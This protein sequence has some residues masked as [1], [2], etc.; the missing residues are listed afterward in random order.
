MKDWT[1]FT[2]MGVVQFLMASSLVGSILMEPG[3]MRRPRYSTLVVLKVHLES[4]RARCSLWR[5]WRTCLV[6]S[7]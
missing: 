6:L 2:S 3:E 4:L 1:A 7:W 5:C